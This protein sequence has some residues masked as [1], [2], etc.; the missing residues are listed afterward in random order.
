MM[1]SRPLVLLAR[2]VPVEAV[3]NQTGAC[4]GWHNRE[5]SSASTRSRHDVC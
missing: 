2:S 1:F 4:S 5:G 3:A